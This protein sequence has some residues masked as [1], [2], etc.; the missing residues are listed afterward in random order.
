MGIISSDITEQLEIICFSSNFYLGR[1]LCVD[2]KMKLRMCLD[3]S[4]R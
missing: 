1:F 2:A 4:A 3:S